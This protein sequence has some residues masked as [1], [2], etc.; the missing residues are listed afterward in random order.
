MHT[1]QR[2]TAYMSGK[3]ARQSATY[4][5][6]MQ[7]DHDVCDR[8]CKGLGAQQQAQAPLQAPPEPGVEV[9]C[10][11]AGGRISNI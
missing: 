2:R 3:P 10:R 8:A 11:K 6:P 5:H 4:T 9:L 1:A 7:G